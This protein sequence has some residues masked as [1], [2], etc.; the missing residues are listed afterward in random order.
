L[1]KSGAK[2]PNAMLLL[3]KIYEK[4]GQ[5]VEKYFRGAEPG[6]KILSQVL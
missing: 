2:N 3:E 5:T 1:I 6:A 4:A